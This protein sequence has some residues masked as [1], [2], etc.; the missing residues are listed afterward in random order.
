MD[1]EILNESLRSINESLE[2]TIKEQSLKME[3][4]Q[5]QIDQCVFIYFL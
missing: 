2:C 1:L 3:Q 4:L 5:L